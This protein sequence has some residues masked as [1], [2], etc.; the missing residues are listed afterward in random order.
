MITLLVSHGVDIDVRR[1]GS[2]EEGTTVVSTLTC[3]SDQCSIN[4]ARLE[5]TSLNSSNY[6]KL[7]Q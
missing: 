5:Q 7:W 1:P 4:V 6:S 2:I 3:P